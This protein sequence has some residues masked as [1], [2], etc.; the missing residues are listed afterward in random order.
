MLRVLA[1]LLI[2]SFCWFECLAQSPSESPVAP[3]PDQPQETPP[4]PALP[5]HAVVYRAERRDAI[6]DYDVDYGVVRRMVDNLVME[7]TGASSVGSAW[8]SLVKPTDKVGIKVSTGGAPLFS[9]HPAIVKAIV[10]GLNEAGVPSQN[11]IVWDREAE[12]LYR[13]GFRPGE[14]FRLMWSEGNYDPKVVVTSAT[15]GR[16]VYGDLMFVGRRFPSFQ[17]EAT[18]GS[19]SDRRHSFGPPED[20]LSSESH[21]SNVLT[22]LVTKVI[23]VPVLSDNIYC[24]LSGALYNMTVQNVDNWRRLIQEPGSGDPSIP[25][26]YADPRLG[27]K[28]V[29]TI[30]DGLVA[31]F[32]GGPVGDANYAVQFGTVYASKDPVAIDSIALRKIDQWRLGAKMYP[33]SKQAN[34]LQTAQTYGLGVADLAKIEIHE[35]R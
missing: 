1:I 12:S 34:Y 27:S 33:A 13:A 3:Q 22:R 9:T 16:L 24:G 30:M 7:V 14:G 25:E 35:V 17:K 32:A 10:G 4:E 5:S 23:N 26:T 29:L 20:N 15:L 28:V 11:I 21:V 19:A 31:L 8:A 2:H 6:E 18:H